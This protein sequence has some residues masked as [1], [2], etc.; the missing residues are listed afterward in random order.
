MP[1]RLA[2]PLALQRRAEMKLQRAGQRARPVSAGR[3]HHHAR[4]LVDD[5]QELVFVEDFQRDVLGPRGLARDLGQH[6]RDALP[7]LEPIGR[8]AAAAV[9]PHPAGRNHPPKMDAAVVGKMG[10]QKGVEPVA[11][12][13]GLDRQLHRLRRQ[14]HG[15]AVALR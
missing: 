15:K 4:R 10:C 13:C 2:P 7:R 8:L 11:G 14:R 9:D 5:D 3:M 1:G 6:D 12:F